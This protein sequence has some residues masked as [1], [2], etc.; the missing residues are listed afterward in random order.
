MKK[1]LNNLP[2]RGPRIAPGLAKMMAQSHNLSGLKAHVDEVARTE[3]NMLAGVKSDAE[4]TAALLRQCAIAFKKVE[5]VEAMLDAFERQIA[6]HGG[7][8]PGSAADILFNQ[9]STMIKTLRD[10]MA[11]AETQVAPVGEGG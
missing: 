5:N 4:E 2:T 7:Q 10:V 8:T 3:A 9:A 11:A 1:P 6:T